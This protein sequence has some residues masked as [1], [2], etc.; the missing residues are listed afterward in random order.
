MSNSAPRESPGHRSRWL[1]FLVIGCLLIT[2]VGLFLTLLKNG[3]PILPCSADVPAQSSATGV[4]TPRAPRVGGT[5]LPHQRSGS[6]PARTAEEIV[7]SKVS[8]FARSR[9]EIAHAMA[10]HFKIVVP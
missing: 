5:P 1:W 3:T 7:A 10:R 9:R 8:Q 2:L 4:H 6:E